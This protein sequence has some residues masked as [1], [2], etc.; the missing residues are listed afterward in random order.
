MDTAHAADTETALAV[1]MQA[2]RLTAEGPVATQVVE[3]AAMQV[4]EHAVRPRRLAA[5]AMAAAAVMPADS[6][7]AATVVAVTGKAGDFRI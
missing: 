7:A 6:V 3:P 1:G 5:A 2:V 4:V